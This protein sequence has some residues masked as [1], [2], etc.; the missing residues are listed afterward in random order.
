MNRKKELC[1][2]EC[3]INAYAYSSHILKNHLRLIDILQFPWE[4]THNTT[5]HKTHEIS[6]EE[7]KKRNAEAKRRYGLK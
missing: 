6:N 1:G 4:E 7:I 5:S 2:N 3:A